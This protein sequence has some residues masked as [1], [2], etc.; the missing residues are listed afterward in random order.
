MGLYIEIADFFLIYTGG[1]GGPIESRSPAGGFCLPA[2]QKA[3]LETVSL[4][5][6]LQSLLFPGHRVMERI[7]E[8]PR[9][10]K[11]NEQI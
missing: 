2:F 10:G 11:D 1:K 6:L 4:A 5:L 8:K 7:N 3:A 9:Q